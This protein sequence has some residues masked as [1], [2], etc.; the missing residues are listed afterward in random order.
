[1]IAARRLRTLRLVGTPLARPEDAVRW[2]GA[3]QSQDYAGAKWAIAQRIRHGRDAAVDQA[4]D[5][6]R[7]LRT[8]I[9]RPTWHFV[10][11]EDIRWMQ[12]LTAPRVRAAMKYATRISGVTPAMLTRSHAAIARALEGGHYLTR[13]ELGEAL[14]RARITA[15][16]LRLATLV[17]H[18]EL[19]ALIV[20]GPRRGKQHTYALLDERVP[21]AKARTRDEALAELTRRYF[22]G[23]GPAQARDFAWWSG[24]TMADA[25]AGL[26]LIGGALRREELDGRTWWSSP[27]EPARV[28]PSSS[29]HLLPNYDEFFIAYRDRSACYDRSRFTIRA[30]TMKVL[31][32]HILVVNGMILG[33]WRRLHGARGTTVEVRLLA[34]LSRSERGALKAAAERYGAALDV[35]ARVTMARR[36]P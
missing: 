25:R 32:V 6:G 22:I 36:S 1:M 30:A 5:E 28:R 2:L 3:V 8:H 15:S 26:A 21:P 7:I 18:A 12:Q 24:L 13:E 34:A 20:S 19:D 35:P 11:P 17:M 14:K 23:H 27:D 33:G 16:G 10:L 4:F 29:L 9:L 31:A